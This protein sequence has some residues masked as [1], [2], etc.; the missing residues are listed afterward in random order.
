MRRPSIILSLLWIATSRPV[1]AADPQP[2]PD[3][4]A[5]VQALLALRDPRTHLAPSHPG[6]PGYER[7]AFLYDKAV[8]ALVLEV[9]GHHDE[10]VQMLDYFAQPLR[11]SADQVCE[12]ADLNG[13][14]GILKCYRPD[15]Q[16]RGTVGLVDGLDIGSTRRFGKAQL[17]FTTTPGPLA[18][19]ILA[20]LTV[21]AARYQAEAATLGETLLAMQRPDGGIRDGDRTPDRVYTEPHV[22]AYAAFL[23]LAEV[24][25]QAR[26][27]QVA[28]AAYLWFVAQVLHPVQATIDQGVWADGPHA[29]FA[30][31]A[32]SWTIAG[33]AGDR[34]PLSLADRLLE[35][36]L[37]RGLVQV[38][39]PLPDGR[40]PTLI[41]CDFSDARDPETQRLRDGVHP[42]GSVEWTGGV[43]LA[44]QKQAT[45]AW[46]AE[47]Q[48]TA[49]RQKALAEAL[50]AQTEQAFYR[51]E[52][53]GRITFY[54][55]G[56][57]VDVGPFGTDPWNRIHGWHTPFFHARDASGQVVA[58]GGSF[59]GALPLLPRH[60]LN[61]FILHDTYRTTY[62]KI[63]HEA[64]DREAAEAFLREAVDGRTYVES[65][66]TGV[67][68]AMTELIEPE[69]Y[70]HRMWAALVDADRA[71]AEGRAQEAARG[72]AETI[73]WARRTVEHPVWRRLAEEENQRKA[74]DVGGLIW[75]PWGATFPHN[76]GDLH[77]AILRYPLLNEVG[78]AM[79][80]S[81]I[82]S[83]ELGLPEQTR[84]WMGELI[85]ELPLHQ[86]AAVMKDPET[87]QLELINGYSN[88]L[89][90]W[91][92]NPGHI[93]RD[94][95]MQPLYL[96]VLHALS[97][98][99]ARPP[100]KRLSFD[101]PDH[102]HKHQ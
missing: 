94:S 45:R 97:R 51:L 33:P 85:E 9:T 43:I 57:G 52:R 91:E 15:E 2:D 79:W 48:A 72:Y 41:L 12:V 17:Q 66:P 68:T 49:R 86:V 30:T 46:I 75:Y 38:T 1:F 88:A 42:M 5:I 61:P 99:S 35:T 32:Y 55:T 24:T 60:G 54:A 80:V 71:K 16:V 81:A 44:L 28:E 37:R 3:A 65:V 58:S 101:H 21:D 102:D 56:Q 19:V 53:V 18:F 13:V 98:D 73:L 59:V 34:L 7:L 36:M 95:A 63:P 100:T 62:D 87:G 77:T 29:I 22:D 76:E 14:D 6:H 4:E 64:E 20:M 8:D 10:A 39:V 96:Q 70:N 40:A 74:R 26:W 78:A 47:D 93:A 31:D 84:Y 50:V 90:S 89:V 23:M 92:D 82:A 27:H 83:F 67:P 69:W 25:G 11:T